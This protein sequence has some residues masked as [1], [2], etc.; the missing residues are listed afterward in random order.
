MH[1][2]PNPIPTQF[3]SERLVIRCPRHGDGDAVYAAVVETLELLRAWPNSLPWAQHEPSPE[4]SEAFCQTGHD[5]YLQGIDMPMLLF[6]KEGNRFAGASGLHRID[7]RLPKFEMGY[8]CRKQFQNRGLMVEAATAINAFAHTVLDARRVEIITHEMNAES[9]AVA[10]RC[11]FK[12]ESIVAKNQSVA[13]EHHYRE[14]IYAS[15]PSMHNRL[16]MKHH[17]LC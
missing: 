14:C 3:E 5:N 11:G 16:Q 8:W 2:A 17:P 12:L 13:G 4:A 7:W 10:V 1:T 6:L 15:P 9:R